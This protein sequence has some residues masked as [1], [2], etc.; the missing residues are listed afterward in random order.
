MIINLERTR[1]EEA[2]EFFRPPLSEISSFSIS[3]PFE[4]T[5]N[6]LMSRCNGTHVNLLLSVNNSTI[7]SHWRPP[8]WSSGQSSLPQIQIQ[9]FG[10]DFRRYQIFWQVV[11]LERGPVSLMS[12][13]EELLKRKSSGSGLESREY[14]SRDPSRWPR[15]TLYSQKLALSSLTSG[16]RSAG[17]VRSRIQAT[18]F[19]L[20]SHYY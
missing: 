14:G 13:T 18:E 7:R 9:R 20:A 6:A 5:K 3:L 17:I 2:R 16:G 10:F 12:T 11:G 15:G 19:P 1:V 4:E 8:L